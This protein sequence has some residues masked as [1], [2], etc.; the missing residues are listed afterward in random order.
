MT[1]IK[2]IIDLFTSNNKECAP[3]TGGIPF[4]VEYDNLTYMI[5][6]SVISIRKDNEWKTYEAKI[7]SDEAVDYTLA[8]VRICQKTYPGMFFDVM[9]I[10][11]KVVELKTGEIT[12]SS[13]APEGAALI[14]ELY[15]SLYDAYQHPEDNSEIS[16]WQI[17]LV[18]SD[19]AG[20]HLLLLNDNQ[21]KIDENVYL[22]DFS[23]IIKALQFLN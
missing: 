21:V 15:S 9:D 16:D 17:Q 19:L 23:N 20:E 11:G 22:S 7:T 18:L 5:T 13:D 1:E 10:L 4:Y 14:R 2:A 3:V 6:A 12:V 8:I